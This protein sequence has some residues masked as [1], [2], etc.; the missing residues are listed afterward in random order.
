MKPAGRQISDTMAQPSQP[1]LAMKRSSSLPLLTPTPSGFA[2]KRDDIW[3][4]QDNARLPR[5]LL[6][7]PS[8]MNPRQMEPHHQQGLEKLSPLLLAGVAATSGS[9]PASS[10]VTSRSPSRRPTAQKHEAAGR[11]GTTFP[12]ISGSGGPPPVGGDLRY[13]LSKEMSLG[14]WP[15]FVEVATDGS[16]LCITACRLDNKEVT[17]LV[18][19]EENHSRL[20]GA[21][22]GDYEEIMRGLRMRG[23]ALILEQPEMS[24]SRSSSRYR[25]DKSIS[26]KMGSTDSVR[27]VFSREMTLGFWPYFVEMATDE[28]VLY[29]SAC[30]MDTKEVIDLLISEENHAKL[31]EIANGD[32]KKII[33]GLRM[34]GGALVLKQLDS[35]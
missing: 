24:P 32:Y 31:L 5:Q 18:V 27:Y 20:L 33:K 13:I 2:K 8:A 15:H 21:T 10:R 16:V 34:D 28:K 23:G 30:K 29:I 1:C 11:G 35:L 25:K 7:P 19:S 14:C 4:P 12:D 22:N 17:E 26:K 9:S 6:M 3:V